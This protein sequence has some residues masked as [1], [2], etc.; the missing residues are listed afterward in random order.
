MFKTLSISVLKWFHLLSPL[1]DGRINNI[2]L[3]TVPHI[4]DVWY[5]HHQ[6]RSEIKLPI[7]CI[8]TY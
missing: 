3:Q 7:D 5:I 2:L 1:I 8:F 6:V 4:N